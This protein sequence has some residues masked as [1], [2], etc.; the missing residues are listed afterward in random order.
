MLVS[1]AKWILQLKN[2]IKFIA[3]INAEKGLGMKRMSKKKKNNTRQLKELI[4]IQT[5]MFY[6]TLFLEQAGVIKNNQF[7]KDAETDFEDIKGAISLGK[8]VMF[9]LSKVKM[10]LQQKALDKANSIMQETDNSTGFNYLVFVLILLMNYKENF[11]NKIYHLPISYDELNTLFDEKDYIEHG[12]V[13][14][15]WKHKNEFKIIIGIKKHTNVYAIK[16]LLVHELSHAVT[17]LFNE[18]N[19]NCD[20]LRSYTL[21]WLYQT[22]MPSLDERLLKDAVKRED[23]AHKKAQSGKGKKK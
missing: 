10:D 7:V 18:Y 20:E 4:L 13:C 19:F 8:K 9:V 16:G 17:M 1:N 2:Q 21:Q 22:I 15:A 3:V 12:G 6:L 14:T 23:K 5:A 11:T